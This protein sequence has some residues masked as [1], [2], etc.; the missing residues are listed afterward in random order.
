IY[1]DFRTERLEKTNEYRLG[2]VI[3]QELHG[4]GTM[5]LVSIDPPQVAPDVDLAL[6]CTL[7]NNGTKPIQLIRYDVYVQFNERWIQFTHIP[8]RR[9]QY[10]VTHPD[11]ANQR[12]ERINVSN[13]S[14]DD[15]IR[16]RALKPGE[17]MGGWVFLK[18]QKELSHQFIL[19]RI[20]LIAR[21]S[22]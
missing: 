20:R 3:H 17:T 11:E 21:D 16:S 2:A 1:K 15:V 9:P 4:H 14:L 13:N 22:E 10:L 18:I 5:E 12:S 6:Q 19:G 7:I 8:I